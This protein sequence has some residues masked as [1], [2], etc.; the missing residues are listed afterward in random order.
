[1]T[2]RPDRAP[3]A[4]EWYRRSVGVAFAGTD[5][6]SGVASCSSSSYTGPDSGQAT[7]NGTC[8]DMAGNTGSGSFGLKFDATAPAATAA[9]NRPPDRSG[10]YNHALTVTFKGSDGSRGWP[11]A[12]RP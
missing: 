2:G 10:W 4:G 3:D 8:T 7:V 5:A 9:A 1:M 12:T 11:P 6:T